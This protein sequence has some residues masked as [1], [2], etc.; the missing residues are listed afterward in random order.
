MKI[1]PVLQLSALLSFVAAVS[2]NAAVLFARAA[3]SSADMTAVIFG[4]IAI[5]LGIAGVV[6]A[7]AAVGVSV[8]HFVVQWE[9]M[10]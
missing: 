2:V 4:C 10:S 1:H 7:F 9:K 5:L 6:A 3:D 8:N